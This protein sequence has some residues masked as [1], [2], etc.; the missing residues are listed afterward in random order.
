[1]RVTLARSIEDKMI[2]L[3]TR[4]LLRD[5]HIYLDDETWT[6]RRARKE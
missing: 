6:T 4:G 2:I 3:K 1:V 5:T